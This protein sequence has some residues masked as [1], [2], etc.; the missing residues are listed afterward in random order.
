MNQIMAHSCPY[1]G[2]TSVE[3]T[4]TNS[5]PVQEC[6]CD[7]GHHWEYN[8]NTKTCK[9]LLKKPDRKCPKCKSQRYENNDFGF[10]HQGVKCSDCGATFIIIY[11]E[12]E[13]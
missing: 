4:M 1:A 10:P 7:N 13:W 12:D 2:C 3:I 5:H 9:P 6:Y 11:D 8:R